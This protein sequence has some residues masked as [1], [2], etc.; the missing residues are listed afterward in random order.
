MYTHRWRALY[1]LCIEL[2]K[3]CSTHKTQHNYTHVIPHTHTHAACSCTR[4]PPNHVRDV[5][6]CAVCACAYRSDG[7]C[8]HVSH[9]AHVCVHVCARAWS[10]SGARVLKNNYITYIRVRVHTEREHY[11][12]AFCVCAARALA[13]ELCSPISARTHRTAHTPHARDVM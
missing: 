10:L 9:A 12:W 2:P 11:S 1:M 4:A 6:V 7:I 8:A 3:G 5:V 13:R